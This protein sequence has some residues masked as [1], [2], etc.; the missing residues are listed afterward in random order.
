MLDET[1]A[2]LYEVPVKSLNQAV[3]RNR[4]RFPDDLVFQLTSDESDHLRSQFVTSNPGG[5]GGRRYEPYAFTEQGVAML[6]SVLRSERAVRVNIEIR[7]AFVR[8]RRVLLEHAELSRKVNQ[9]EKNYDGQFRVV[10]D[11]LRELMSPPTKPRARIGFKREGK[12]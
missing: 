1:L 11:V 9:L 7:R 3:K 2:E 8:M 4:E 6:S 10:F 5:R 12:S